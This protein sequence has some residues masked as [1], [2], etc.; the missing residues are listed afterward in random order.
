MTSPIEMLKNELDQ[1]NS[2]FRNKINIAPPLKLQ[3]TGEDLKRKFNQVSVPKISQDQ[4]AIAIRT[5]QSQGLKSTRQL[6]VLCWNLTTKL[7]D[8]SQFLDDSCLLQFFKDINEL[9]KQN[10]LIST[11][12]WRGLLHNYFQRK[13]DAENASAYTNWQTLQKFLALTFKIIK[14]LPKKT[15]PWMELL[16]QHPQLFFDNPC[17]SYAKAL[18][19]GNTTQLDSLRELIHEGSWFWG[20]IILSQIKQVTE[21]PDSGFKNYLN[22]ML[23]QLK[24]HP[25][26]HDK[27]LKLILIRYHQC[28]DL[29]RHEGLRD[30]AIECWGSPQLIRQAKWGLVEHNV[31][32]MVSQWL[33]LEDLEEFFNILQSDRVGD[34]RRYEFWKQYLKQ[35]TYTQ[36]V[37]GND[38]RY[39]SDPDYVEFRNKRKKNNRLSYLKDAPSSTN[40]FIMRIGEYYFVEFSETGNACYGY[41]IDGHLHSHVPSERFTIYTLKHKNESVFWGNHSGHQWEY[42][43]KS[44]LAKLGIDPDQYQSHFPTNPP[45]K[46]PSIEEIKQ[47][48]FPYEVEDLRPKGGALWVRYYHKLNG[49]PHEDESDRKSVISRFGKQLEQWGFKLYVTKGYWKQ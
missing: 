28:S 43:F 24:T 41:P 18:L 22:Q 25:L 10:Q 49:T 2:S 38:A 32:N 46:P 26:Y 44:E 29:M 14:N 23:E 8:N 17:P 4:L 15:L 33:A 7:K 34:S 5:Y 27:G 13:P 39:S 30:F 37:L 9:L 12:W 1:Q 21:L 6:R 40:A 11:G 3:K 16:S 47:Y 42:G 31:K 36:I 35:I 48:V 19:D 20:E 45:N